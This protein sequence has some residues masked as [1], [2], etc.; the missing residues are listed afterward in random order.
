[1]GPMTTPI[2]RTLDAIQES[3]MPTYD[4]PSPIH[5]VIDVMGDIRIAA[6]DRTDTIVIVQPRDTAKRADVEAAGETSVVREG[7]TI[8]IRIPKRW[9]RF[10]PFGGGESVEVVVELPTGSSVDATTGLGD[11]RTEGEL[12]DCRLKS[13]MGAIRVDR[14]GDLRATTGH[15]A[16]TID[17]VAGAADIST[18]SGEVQLGSVEGTASVKNSNGRTS[19]H[20][21]RG[22]AR[23][24]AANGDVMVERALGSIA[25]RSSNG[26]VRVLEAHGGTAVLESAV[27]ELEVGIPEGV[28][29]WLDLGSR[30][31]T[32]RNDLESTDG[33]GGATSTV[34]VRAH[35]GVGHVIV[36]RADP[37]AR[38]RPGGTR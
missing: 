12:G 19:I 26:D 5:L 9:M 11:I 24:K 3:P 7:D 14:A 13:G 35:T 6:S 16:I 36:R 34:E 30:Y 10:T 32:V 28:A 20:E 31:G 18:G 22:E 29:A 37:H 23:V 21:T 27:G 2:I 17:H 8:R 33:P 4:T 25:A 15:G 38:T 1:M